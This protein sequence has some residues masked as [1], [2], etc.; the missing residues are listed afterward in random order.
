VLVAGNALEN[1]KPG[2]FHRVER[3]WRDGDQV[4]V[5]FP[6]KTT[7][8]RQVN[9]SVA[10][11]RGPLVYSLLIEEERNSTRSYLDGKFHTQEIRPASAWNYALLLGDNEASP[12]ETTV[13]NTMPPQPFRAADSSVRL[14]L[15]AATTDQGG[16]GTY[17][18]RWPGRAV[19]PPTSPVNTVGP[20]E[21]IV[22]V[23]YG[24]TE[25]RITCFPWS[26]G[27]K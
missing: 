11:T 15:K 4:E 21:D 18:E 20:T 5:R 19:E 14:T 25:I 17:Q 24:S 9:N 1:V 3:T 6:M 2:T 16:W 27:K 26:K 22:L 7:L 10:V 12:I 13:A 23:P 8:S